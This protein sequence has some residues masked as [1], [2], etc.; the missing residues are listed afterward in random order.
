MKPFVPFAGDD[1]EAPAARRREA[2][3]RT[4][5]A[6]G[7]PAS[8]TGNRARRGFGLIGVAAALLMLLWLIVGWTGMVPSMIDIFG[9]PGLRIPAGIAVGGLLMAAIGFNE[10]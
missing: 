6:V 5:A 9:I 7:G 2:R 8:L 1:D 10:F 4:S 3:G